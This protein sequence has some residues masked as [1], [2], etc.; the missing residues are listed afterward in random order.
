M[1]SPVLFYPSN[2]INYL[3]IFIVLILFISAKQSPKLF[4][5][6]TI[7]SGF[8]DLIDGPI[9]REYKLTSK[10]GGLIDVLLDRATSIIQM[11]CLSVLYPRYWHIFCLTSMTE[12]LK[13]FARTSVSNL[14]RMITFLHYINNDEKVVAFKKISDEVFSAV[15]IRI[16]THQQNQTLP[17]KAQSAPAINLAYDYIIDQSIW[18]SSD[19]FYLVIYFGAFISQ[20]KTQSIQTK[21]AYLS[22]SPNSAENSYSDS[23]DL[24]L[25]TNNRLYPPE[26]TV[27]TKRATRRNFLVAFLIYIREFSTHMVFVFK[28]IGAS[29]ERFIEKKFHCNKLKLTHLFAF[30]GIVCLIGAFFK[31]YYNFKSLVLAALELMEIDNQLV[32]LSEK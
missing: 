28:E 17:L 5:F 4:V 30:F 16:K 13:D 23:E 27:I 21:K 18:Y 26:L 24:A 22:K 29:I 20:A 19:I 31:F 15:N 11:Y 3:R 9:A 2:V 8:I 6:C 14:S 7:A 10:Y 12:M 25:P 32:Y 1:F